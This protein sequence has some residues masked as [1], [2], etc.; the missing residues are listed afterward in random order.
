MVRQR[1]PHGAVV[2]AVLMLLLVLCVSN[3]TVS[4]GWVPHSEVL[5]DLALIAALIM[6]VLAVTR[7]PWPLALGLG[8][9][10]APFAGYLASYSTVYAAHP[11]DPTDPLGLLAV[12][13]RRVTNGEA[14]ADATFY[15]YLLSCLFWVVGGWLSWCVLRWRQPLLGL[16]PGAAAFATNVLNY[17]TDQNGYTLAF[18]IVT[19]SLLLW[20]SYLRSLDGASRRR[21]KLTGD[22]RWDFW[23]SGVVVMAAV[24][25]LGIFLPPLSN[26]DRTV[27]IENGSFRGWAELQQ[28][29]NHPVAFGHGQSDGTSI[30]FATDVALGGPIRKTGGVVMTYT[31]DGNFGGPRYFRGLNLER[32][33]LG[34]DGSAWRYG[35]PSVAFPVEKDVP[36][37]Y[38]EQYQGEQ[39][40][41]F[42]IHML[43]PPDKASD[44]LFY[45]GR[46]MKIDRNATGHSSVGL[47][48]GPGQATIDKLN[49]LDRLSGGTR[50]SGA[51]TYRIT[52][53]Y[54]NATEDQLR[55]AGSDYPGWL[56]PYR[57]F[58]N[59]YSSAQASTSQ[60]SRLPIYRNSDTL[61][62]IHDLAVQV[63]AGKDNP[64]DQA[65]AIETYLR[66]NY[67]YTLTP[68]AP[69]RD[70]DALEYFLFTSKQGYC[71]YFASAMGDM[72]RSLGIPTRLVN[73][74][75]PGS[76]DEKLSR[77]VVRESDAHTWVEV[78][79]PHYGWIPFEPTPDGTY[80]PIQR[81][82][83]SIACGRDATVCDSGAASPVSAGAT[84][85]RP[86]K[87]NIDSGD[88]TTTG[89]GRLPVPVQ[90]PIAL[91]VLLLLAAAAW[92]MV[93]RYLRPRTVNGVWRRVTLLTNLAGMGRREAE[94]PLEF[95]ARLAKEM[96]EAA[97]PA[98]EL[99]ERFTVAAYA[100]KEM[101]VDALSPV[102][103]VWEELRPML[104]RRVRL[105]FHLA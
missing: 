44:V 4:A 6:G 74:Y 70:L 57:N 52:V 83:N 1:V 12:W 67:S 15:L 10:A 41:G 2:S 11:Q 95:G 79:H 23:E 32:T 18:L 54:S 13:S 105:R 36:P 5:T 39:T 30:G 68:S 101:A 38:S 43:K 58:T 49:T 94:T 100:P 37:Q 24:I 64:Y 53:Q 31:V 99:A 61:Q 14:G 46:L 47:V 55:L 71:E 63:T 26:A 87:G 66:A 73:G 35:Q 92:V 103:A 77:Y 19:L 89:T 16:I 20:T 102:L 88:L 22:A 3:S 48:S 60:A 93:S 17:P 25:A 29:L 51:G 56:D 27:D 7:V 42:K 69:P 81:G 78:Y 9:A 72:L 65:Q 97:K 59:T 34:L 45:P 50:L 96:P 98:G 62:R 91:G 40:G 85:P 90:F 75:G 21:V 80:F 8:L 86:D 33:S 104:M 76:F 84:N 82:S 28:R